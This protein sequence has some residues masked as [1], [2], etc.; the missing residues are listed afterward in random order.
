M[1]IIGSSRENTRLKSYEASTKGTASIVTIKIEIDDATELWHV[2]RELES[3][4]AQQDAARKAAS[5]K[6]PAAPKG[7]RKI[8]HTPLLALPPPDR[9]EFEL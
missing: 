7:A 2:L 4:K 8:E 9:S 5:R 3:V 1:L 6:T